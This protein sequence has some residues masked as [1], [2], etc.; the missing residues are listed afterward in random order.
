M[1]DGIQ[2]DLTE[3]NKL[4]ADLGAAPVR[5]HGNIRKAVEVT[6]RHVKDDWRKDAKRQNPVHAK[7]YPFKVS[8]DVDESATGVTA[9]IGP[10]LGGQGSLGILEDGG[11]GI[12]SRPQRSG[13][14]AAKRNEADFINGLTK[15]IG[16]I[17]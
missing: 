3:L 14:K 7:G 5:A 11:G 9:E 13:Q 15:A 1:A 16:D 10:E 17:L 6:A 2:F 8:Y 12:K 4:A